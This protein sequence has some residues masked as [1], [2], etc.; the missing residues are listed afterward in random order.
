VHFPVLWPGDWSTMPRNSAA[1][2]AKLPRGVGQSAPDSAGGRQWAC[3]RRAGGKVRPTRRAQPPGLVA[4]A[5]VGVVQLHLPPPVAWYS[6]TPAAG[7]MVQLHS[8]HQWNGSARHGHFPPSPVRP[9]PEAQAS[10]VIRAQAASRARAVALISSLI[11]EAGRLLPASMSALRRGRP[12]GYRST[13]SPSRAAS[14]ILACDSALRATGVRT[15]PTILPGNRLGRRT[16]SSSRLA[17]ARQRRRWA[18]PPCSPRSSLAAS[19]RPAS[20]RSWANRLTAP[21]CYLRQRYEVGIL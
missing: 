6:S 16:A 14:M 9:Y 21:T 13:A 19:P 8:R 15:R 2:H 10:G 7:G 18:A 3:T 11:A 5:R 20:W 12:P 1:Y 4:H 17:T